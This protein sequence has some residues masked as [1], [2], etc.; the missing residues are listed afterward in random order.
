MVKCPSGPL[1]VPSR[2]GTTTTLAPTKG[3]PVCCSSTTPLI[4]SP[5]TRFSLSEEPCLVSIRLLS[6]GAVGAACVIT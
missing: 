2:V 6:G 3:K 4:S 5:V 1:T